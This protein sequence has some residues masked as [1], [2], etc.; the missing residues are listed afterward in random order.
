MAI[1]KTLERTAV[2]RFTD[3]DPAVIDKKLENSIYGDKL[4]VNFARRLVRDIWRARHVP[5]IKRP[6]LRMRD[7]YA[8]LDISYS[9]LRMYL[10]DGELGRVYHDMSGNILLSLEQ[11]YWLAGKLGKREWVPDAQPIVRPG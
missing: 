6:R 2:I 7:V 11:F 4:P 3:I 8:A 9:T 1:K 10:R 5:D